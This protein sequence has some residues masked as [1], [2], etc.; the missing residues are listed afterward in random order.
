MNDC[1]FQSRREVGIV[2]CKLGHCTIPIYCWLKAKTGMPGRKQIKTHTRLKYAHFFYFD[3]TKKFSAFMPLTKQQ[4]DR[5][6]DILLVTDVDVVF[7]TWMNS[8]R[9]RSATFWSP[10]TARCSSLTPDAVSPR[11][12]AVLVPER[13]TRN[14]TVKPSC[15]SCFNQLN[16]LW[17]NECCR[18]VLCLIMSV[19]ARVQ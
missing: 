2:F 8:P 1:A 10:T 19:H 12:L 3:K 13:A 15:I 4:V 14:H 17:V 5:Y 18:V 9:R 7:Q 6:F 11:S 16:K